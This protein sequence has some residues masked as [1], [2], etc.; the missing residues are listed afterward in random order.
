MLIGRFKIWWYANVWLWWRMR[1][2]RKACFRCIELPQDQALKQIAEWEKHFSLSSC[3][4]DF[5]KAVMSD[6]ARLRLIVL[7]SPNTKDETRHGDGATPKEK[8]L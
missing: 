3:D 5:K 8:T 2:M 1:R 7:S 4:D 6:M